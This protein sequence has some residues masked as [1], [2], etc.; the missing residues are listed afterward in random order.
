MANL[1]EFVAKISSFPFN[2]YR[3][4]F[5]AKIS[6]QGFIL[7]AVIMLKPAN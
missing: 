1:D 7:P 6:S 2:N 3:S 5:P 4:K